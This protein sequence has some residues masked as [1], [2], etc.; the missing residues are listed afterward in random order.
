[1]KKETKVVYV[2]HPADVPEQRECWAILTENNYTGGYG[3]DCKAW[4]FCIF[5]NDEE[6][7]EEI[8]KRETPRGYSSSPYIPLRV[9]RPKLETSIS[10]NL[11]VNK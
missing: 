10:I 9:T 2:H 1:M 7:Y 3:E 4:E 6:F 5:L 8:K 11:K